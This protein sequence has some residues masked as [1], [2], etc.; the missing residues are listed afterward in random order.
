MTDG[1]WVRALAF[2]KRQQSCAGVLR[3]ARWRCFE[4]C[5]MDKINSVAHVHG[6][7]ETGVM[8]YAVESFE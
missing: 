1:C 6:V 7:D 5:G 3:L 2:M 4:F 8:N